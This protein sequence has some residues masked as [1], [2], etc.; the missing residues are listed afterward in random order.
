VSGK[1]AVPGAGANDVFA[2]GEVGRETDSC[3]LLYLLTE[4]LL[5]DTRTE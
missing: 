5:L 4:R 2:D 3:T 1:G